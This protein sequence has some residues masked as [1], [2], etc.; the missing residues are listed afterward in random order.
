[1]QKNQ[2]PSELHAAHWTNC[3]VG[4]ICSLDQLVQSAAQ[5]TGPMVQL[6]ACSLLGHEFF[7]KLQKQNILVNFVVFKGANWTS[8]ALGTSSKANW[9]SSWR[10]CAALAPTLSG[11]VHSSY[12][13]I[14]PIDLNLKS[15]FFY[16]FW[17]LYYVPIDIFLSMYVPYQIMFIL[18]IYLWAYKTFHQ[19]FYLCLSCLFYSY[20]YI[21]IS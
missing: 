12:R 19:S 20:T 5:R 16:L 17:I 15:I 1:M 14:K 18:V 9:G 3:S 10:S 21:Q 4:T 7:C 13:S 11:L 2:W 6:A 8:S